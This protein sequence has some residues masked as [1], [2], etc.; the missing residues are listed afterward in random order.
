M[1]LISTLNKQR[2]AVGASKVEKPST[3]STRSTPAPKAST[4]KPATSSSSSSSSKST[5]TPNPRSSAAAAERSNDPAYQKK[6]IESA[7][8]KDPKALASDYLQIINALPPDDQKRYLGFFSEFTRL[9][10]EDQQNFLNAM[11]SSANQAVDPYYDMQQKRN[12]EDYQYNLDNIDMRRRHL[13]STYDRLVNDVNEIRNRN[14]YLEKKG[15]AQTIFGLTNSEF[16]SGLSGSG[17]ARR[18]KAY[19]RDATDENI[20]DINISSSQQIGR[21]GLA[22]G[23]DLQ[24]LDK[25]QEREGVLKE[26]TDFDLNQNRLYDQESTFL[27]LL[28][29]DAADIGE[30]VRRNVDTGAAL[31]D[32]GDDTASRKSRYASEQAAKALAAERDTELSRRSDM[33]KA[34]REYM[35]LNALLMA[36]NSL[37][38]GDSAKNTAI[39]GRMRELEPLVQSLGEGARRNEKSMDEQRLGIGQMTFLGSSGTGV[40]WRDY[41]QRN[42]ED[43]Y[44]NNYLI[45]TGLNNAKSYFNQTF[46]DLAF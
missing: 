42:S 22:L 32:T 30:S 35:N 37:K 26:R 21:A 9:P 41:V 10:A 23:Q 2:Q 33:A 1:V 7:V 3:R 40:D 4:S 17:I 14:T 31:N 13:Q 39:R 46:P 36:M 19:A 5:T 18:R 27:D 45:A 12:D 28:G 34:A 15:L 20:T 25:A 38:I 24:A 29:N 16:I 44:K 6:A 8:N 11:R 43:I